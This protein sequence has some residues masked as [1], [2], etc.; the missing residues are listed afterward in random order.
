MDL[1]TYVDSIREQNKTYSSLDPNS[2]RDW[3][4]NKF[5]TDAHTQMTSA[6]VYRNCRYKL[7]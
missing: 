3:R 5:L 6:A 1:E 7:V 4:D 2:R